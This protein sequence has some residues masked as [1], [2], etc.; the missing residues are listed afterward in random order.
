MVEVSKMVGDKSDVDKI[1]GP[2]LASRLSTD[3]R[4]IKIEPRQVEEKSEVGPIP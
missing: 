4:N 3:L 2:V 1:L